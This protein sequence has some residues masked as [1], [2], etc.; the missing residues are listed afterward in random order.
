MT[1]LTHLLVAFELQSL[2][3]AEKAALSAAAQRWLIHVARTPRPGFLARD[4]MERARAAC[5]LLQ[6]IGPTAA[7]R[8]GKMSND[9]QRILGRRQYWG[10]ADSLG[11]ASRSLILGG[12]T[13]SD[14]MWFVIDFRC[15][16]FTTIC[17]LVAER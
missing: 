7:A 9:H 10:H 12:G 13:V 17:M 4:P 2:A 16:R 1:G 15:D 5:H 6:G 3:L 11:E 8:V 14:C